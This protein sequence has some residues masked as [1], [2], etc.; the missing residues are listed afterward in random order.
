[1]HTHVCTP[2]TLSQNGEQYL[3]HSPIQVLFL[4]QYVKKVTCTRNGVVCRETKHQQRGRSSCVCEFCG[5]RKSSNKNPNR[6]KM[7]S[8]RWYAVVL[9][10]LGSTGDTGDILYH[11][12][13]HQN[14]NF[15]KRF[16]KATQCPTQPAHLWNACCWV[17]MKTSQRGTAGSH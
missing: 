11:Q 2:Y 13:N 8:Y 17:G 14:M 16:V 6:A 7:D 5:V 4:G 10:E 15:G 3:E 12:T 1:M 9:P